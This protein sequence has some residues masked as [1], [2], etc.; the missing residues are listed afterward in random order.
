MK[1]FLKKV[2]NKTIYKIRYF[3]ANTVMKKRIDSKNNF[4]NIMNDVEL[5]DDIVNNKKSYARFGD[6]ELSLILDKNFN[7]SFQK[8]SEELS[9]KLNEIL[10]SNEKN[11]IIGINR[12]F[13]NPD[14]Y[15]K[16]VVKYCRAFNYIYREKYKKIIPNNKIYGNSSITRFYID[17]DTSDKES[18]YK[19]INNLKRIWSNKNILIVEGEKTKLGVGNDLFASSKKIRRII[20][21]A[22]NAF[23]KKNEIIDTI[24]KNKC[25]N[26]IVLIAAGPTATILAYE[27]SKKGVQAID[28]GHIDIEYEW[29]IRGTDKRIPIEGKYINEL[30]GK[31]YYE[32]NEID[33]D[34][35][36][37][38]IAKIQ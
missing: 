17:Y 35:K 6:G 22:I 26:E 1:K 14:E 7:I 10:N 19:R 31:K 18:A 34:Y 24:I 8:N 20:V 2:V 3:I 37:S 15:N 36:N 16:K 12:S 32:K 21:P 28:I 4:F 38:I 5:V 13:N 25:E 29:L 33:E 23:D 27:L 9:N 30:K 11:L